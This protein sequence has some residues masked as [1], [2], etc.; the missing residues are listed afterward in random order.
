MYPHYFEIV[1]GLFL[2][3]NLG[4]PFI[5]TLFPINRINHIGISTADLETKNISVYR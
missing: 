4:N 2:V 3:V 1:K 5:Y